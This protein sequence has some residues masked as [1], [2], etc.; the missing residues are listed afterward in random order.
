[1]LARLT[2]PAGLAVKL[3]DAKKH[4]RIDHD[5]DDDWLKLFLPVAIEFI[6]GETNLFL[7]PVT[8]QYRMPDWYGAGAREHAGAWSIRLPAAPVRDVERVSYLDKASAEQELAAELW[9]WERVDRHGK[10]DLTY[11]A[12][13]G[14]P[15]LQAN[16]RDVVF[17]TFAAGFDLPDQSGSGDDPAL[18]LPALATAGVL[19]LIG[20]WFENR[21][22]TTAGA[23]S[24]LAPG[25]GSICDKLMSYT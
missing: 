18:Q 21:E 14:R 6:E 15:E 11:D 9:R 8:V 13:F 5:D 10:A 19:L 12:G 24:R 16:R 23:L 25:V 22:E 20:H 1:M 4:L 2:K 7:A 17:I 3:A